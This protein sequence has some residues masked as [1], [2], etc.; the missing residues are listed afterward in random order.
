MKYF[1]II[2]KSSGPLAFA[3]I[4]SFASTEAMQEAAGIVRTA[5]GT[6]TAYPQQ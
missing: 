1:I 6:F 3:G 5:G 2:T 4:I